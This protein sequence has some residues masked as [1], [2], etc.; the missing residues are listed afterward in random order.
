[1]SFRSQRAGRD[2]PNAA[3]HHLPRHPPT[4]ADIRGGC[5]SDSA[6]ESDSEQE[7]G[8]DEASGGSPTVVV[9]SSPSIRTPPVV[10]NVDIAQQV[11]GESPSAGCI[12]CRVHALRA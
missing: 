6:S 2:D 4:F 5:E 1:M 11:I 10:P 3:H 7:A 8:E 9:I 12:V